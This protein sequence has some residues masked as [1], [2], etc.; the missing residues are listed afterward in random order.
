MLA[1][2][3]AFFLRLAFDLYSVALMTLAFDC[4]TGLYNNL[5][6][7]YQRLFF[8]RRS[9]ITVITITF[10]HDFKLWAL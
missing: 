9:L 3:S 8:S 2:K 7:G 1:T 4:P 10:G 6:L 5:A